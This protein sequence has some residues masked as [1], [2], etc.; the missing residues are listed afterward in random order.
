MVSD[1][2]LSKLASEG[3]S[4][5]HDLAQLILRNSWGA[6]GRRDAPD[7]IRCRT[8]KAAETRG[9]MTVAGKAGVEGDGR[10]IGAPL[11]HGVQRVSETFAQHVVVDRGARDLSKHVA[12]VKR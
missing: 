2:V 4:R 1:V 6:A 11:Q 3:S 10:Q 7:L 5:C 8:E 9:K 12:E